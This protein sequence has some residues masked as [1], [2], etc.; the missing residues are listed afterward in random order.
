MTAGDTLPTSD[1]GYNPDGAPTAWI[2]PI[3][4]IDGGTPVA[5]PTT[6]PPSN[7]TVTPVGGEFL[8]NTYTTSEQ[9]RSSVTSLAN[10]GLCKVWLT[11]LGGP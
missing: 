6:P 2:D 1:D 10:S 3:A 7:G 9:G 8:V 11:A 4:F 5:P